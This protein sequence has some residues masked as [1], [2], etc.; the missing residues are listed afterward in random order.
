MLLS[1]KPNPAPAST[2]GHARWPTRSPMS[3]GPPEVELDQLTAEILGRRD[4][5]PRL[6]DRPQP[7]H[8]DEATGS[9]RSID[10]AF[11]A[12]DTRNSGTPLEQTAPWFVPFNPRP[13]YPLTVGERWWMRNGG[14]VWTA[15][16][17]A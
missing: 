8:R 11:E 14:G 12:C 16:S 2:S 1:T 3:A 4:R 10:R 7:R 17:H 9:T 15:D 6:P 13:Q 5:Q